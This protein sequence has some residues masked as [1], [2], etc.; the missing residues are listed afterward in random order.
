MLDNE[1]TLKVLRKVKLAISV[2]AILI[3]PAVIAYE[4]E[5][6]LKA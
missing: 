4:C 6:F 5:E 2:T 1:D 3:N